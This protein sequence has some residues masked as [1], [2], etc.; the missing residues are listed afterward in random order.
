MPAPLVPA[1][2]AAQPAKVRGILSGL[3]ALPAL[4]ETSLAPPSAIVLWEVEPESLASTCDYLA[5]TSAAARS[6]LSP[7]VLQ[8]V[9]GPDLHDGE[10]IVLSEFG[11][12]ATIRHPEDLHR[13]AR[14][15]HGYFAR[16]GQ[17]LD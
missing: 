14:L 16:S 2:I 7:R 17:V 12:A 13:L 1:V 6:G 9:A 3:Q 4:Q 15:I 11:C 8:L 10:R 5:Q